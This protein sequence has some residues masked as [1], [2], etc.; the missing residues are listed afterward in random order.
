MVSNKFGW[1]MG[2]NRLSSAVVLAACLM[3]GGCS[4]FSPAARKAAKIVSA[5]KQDL[6]LGSSLE[7]G[8][9]RPGEAIAITVTAT[10]T[11]DEPLKVRKL[12]ARSLSFMFG[13]KDDDKRFARDPVVSAVEAAQL[14]TTENEMIT[15]NPGQ[16]I[17]R[18]FLMTRFTG[19][20]GAYVAQVHMVPYSGISSDH[21]GKVYGNVMEFEVKG[22]PLCTRDSEGLLMQSDAVRIAVGQG[23]SM[24]EVVSTD[25]ILIQ[26]SEVGFYL[27]WVNLD[28]RKGDGSRVKD[29]YLIDPYRARIKNRA[30]PFAEAM[31]PAKPKINERVPKVNTEPEEEE[32]DPLSP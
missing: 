18:T 17:S 2:S 16:K 22:E 25:A 15:L 10:N 29:S 19:E 23:Q 5:D 8:L 28:I 11:T 21:V 26:D 27:W 32:K 31:K 13:S 9:Y 14:Q 3:A 12:H 4:Y 6:I 20:A 7:K 24:G 30:Q 1:M